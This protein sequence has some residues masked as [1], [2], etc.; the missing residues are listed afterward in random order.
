MRCTVLVVVVVFELVLSVMDRMIVGI[1]KMKLTVVSS[2]FF[3]ALYRIFA[4][5]IFHW[6]NYE[7]KKVN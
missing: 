3:I 1:G 4:F 7:I 5:D 6:H 2:L